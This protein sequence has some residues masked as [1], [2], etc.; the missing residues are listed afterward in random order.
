MAHTSSVEEG[1]SEGPQAREKQG[2]ESGQD[3]EPQAEGNS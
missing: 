3:S 2:M 1:T